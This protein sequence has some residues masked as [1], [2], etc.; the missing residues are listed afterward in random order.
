MKGGIYNVDASAGQF[1]PDWIKVKDHRD[2]VSVCK[3]PGGGVLSKLSHDSDLVCYLFGR[4]T[5]HYACLRTHQELDLDVKEI[6]DV[7]M[8][9]E[10]NGVCRVHMDF[11]QKQASRTLT[12]IAE[13]GTVHWDLLQNRIIFKTVYRADIL[14]DSP[15]F[16][17]N[18]MYLAMLKDFNNMVHQREH[19]CISME[20]AKEGVILINE[21]KKQ[22]CGAGK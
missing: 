15:G 13:A 11:I 10:K 4:M 16:D 14:F 1:L 5:L 7:I 17:S 6:A 9:S 12:I 18:E 21:I 3:T 22:A 20:E 8:L 2:S 19:R